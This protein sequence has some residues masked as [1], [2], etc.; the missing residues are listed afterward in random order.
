MFIKLKGALPVSNIP[1]LV[2]IHMQ[3]LYVPDCLAAGLL[4]LA[5]HHGGVV[6]K[7]HGQVVRQAVRLLG[8]WPG[9]PVSPGHYGGTTLGRL[10]LEREN[11]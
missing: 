5:L 1:P 7:H 8:G 9:T 6:D 11:Y 3:V 10:W 4:V 2:P